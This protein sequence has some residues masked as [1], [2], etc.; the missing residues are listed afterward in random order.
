MIE[1]HESNEIT[2]K[3]PSAKLLALVNEWADHYIKST[4]LPVK[5]MEQAKIEGI[6][7]SI[8]K[9][10]IAMTLIMELS[11]PSILACSI[12]FTGSSVDFM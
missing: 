6:D 4:E 2:N 5:I 1:V 10:I 9:D 11:I 3:K 8:I 12:I 7:N